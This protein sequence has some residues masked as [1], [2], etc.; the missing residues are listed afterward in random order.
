MCRTSC[1]L[2]VTTATPQDLEPHSFRQI[3]APVPIVA[4]L[5]TGLPRSVSVPDVRVYP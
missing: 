2:V 5:S 1:T 4:D 3:R